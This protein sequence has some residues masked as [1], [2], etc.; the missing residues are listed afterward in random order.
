MSCVFTGLIAVLKLSITPVAFIQHI[1]ANNTK[2]THVTCDGVSPT[3]KQYAENIERINELTTV[4]DGYDM[5]AFDP[6]LF[7]VCEL[8]K[9]SI[10]HVYNGIY[11]KYVYT[12][13]VT[14]SPLVVYSNNAH[15]WC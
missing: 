13:G 7:L 11:H 8:Y 4:H 3:E 12:N 15:F 1:K 6:L 10:T 5:S 9:V 2:T 14:T